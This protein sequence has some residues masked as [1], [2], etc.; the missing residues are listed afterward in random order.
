MLHSLRKQS[1]LKLKTRPN[2]LL[3]YLPFAFVLPAQAAVTFAGI[4]CYV[5]FIFIVFAKEKNALAFPRF[6]VSVCGLLYHKSIIIS[7]VCKASVFV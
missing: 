5:L 6:K 3:G 7:L 2:Q 4:S 1:N